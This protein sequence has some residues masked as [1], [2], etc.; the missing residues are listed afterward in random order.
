MFQIKVTEK[1]KTHFTFSGSFFPPENRAIYDMSKNMVQ[2]ERTQTIWRLRVAYWIGKLTRA[3]V[4]A[5]AHA[6]THRNARCHPQK[7][8]TFIAFHGNSGSVNAA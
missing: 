1:I 5:R 7:H 4:H 2:P 6:P 3:Q 8:V